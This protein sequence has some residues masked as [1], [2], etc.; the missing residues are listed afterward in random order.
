MKPDTAIV[1]S[2]LRVREARVRVRNTI[3]SSVSLA[4]G[5]KGE[6]EA[7]RIKRQAEEEEETKETSNG[8]EGKERED[9][10]R[11]G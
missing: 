11:E 3:D 2:S 10:E 4:R 9:T 8:E 6:L 5:R 7:C 1:K